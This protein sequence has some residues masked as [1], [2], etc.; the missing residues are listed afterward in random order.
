MAETL[1]GSVLFERP[2]SG[3]AT[4]SSY[5]YRRTTSW[6]EQTGCCRFASDN[7]SARP[8]GEVSPWLMQG[9]RVWDGAVLV[10]GFVDDKGRADEEVQSYKK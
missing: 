5:E 6:S 10:E 4:S 3:R 1:V 2:R 8:G 7:G 9:R